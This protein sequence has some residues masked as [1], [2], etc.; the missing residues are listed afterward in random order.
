MPRH[1]PSVRRSQP[2]AGGADLCLSE[3]NLAFA[4]GSWEVIS[5]PLG[6]PNWSVFVYL[7]ALD[8]LII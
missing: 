3:Q 7:G 4:P 1:I 2:V 6:S 8:S 5:R